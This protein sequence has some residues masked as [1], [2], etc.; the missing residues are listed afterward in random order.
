[1]HNFLSAYCG[2]LWLAALCVTVKM[3]SILQDNDT[4]KKFS[5]IL[6]NAKVTF[7]RKLWNGKIFLIYRILAKI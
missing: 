7:N 6:E 3:A 1:M 2:G 4:E 5:H